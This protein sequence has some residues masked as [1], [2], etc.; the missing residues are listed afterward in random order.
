MA[1]TAY[2]SVGNYN[3]VWVCV[4]GRGGVCVCV[5]LLLSS[6]CMYVYIATRIVTTCTVAF[7][8]VWVH[9]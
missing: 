9:V 6:Q 1:V 5:A 8:G 3:C 7:L 2:C 4:G